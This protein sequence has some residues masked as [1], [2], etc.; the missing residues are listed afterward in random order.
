[1]RLWLHRE[2]DR[3]REGGEISDRVTA[4]AGSPT[5]PVPIKPIQRRSP[6]H[7]SVV[8]RSLS[9]HS[10]PK[11][12]IQP[13]SRMV[14]IE[15]TGGGGGIGAVH[16]PPAASIVL[17]LSNEVRRLIRRDRPIPSFPSSSPSSFLNSP[18]SISE[19]P[20]SHATHDDRGRRGESG[21][22]ARPE[23][24]AVIAAWATRPI[25]RAAAA[26]ADPPTRTEGGTEADGRISQ[27]V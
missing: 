18:L 10:E 23:I 24:F 4:T 14:L 22:T 25:N 5:F 7:L 11:I 2:R 16:C 27:S 6:P 19:M 12:E 3:E 1:M 9:P 26:A 20:E 15:V 8:L 17:R 13:L 21:P